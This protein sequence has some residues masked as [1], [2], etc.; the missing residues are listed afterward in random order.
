MRSRIPTAAVVVSAVL[1]GI[2][3]A[4]VAGNALFV[5]H[6]VSSLR[7][8]VESLPSIPDAYVPGQLDE[9][10]DLF[11]SHETGLSLSVSFPILDRVREQIV[12]ARAYA[13]MGKEADYTAAL[14]VL[15][16][17]IRD[18]DRLER[19]SARNIM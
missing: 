10:S 8:K 12:T 11:S 9:L 5:H 2:I 7:D 4:F 18:L 15:K 3:L 17:V 6:T 19:F 13:V 1:L 16:D 14:A